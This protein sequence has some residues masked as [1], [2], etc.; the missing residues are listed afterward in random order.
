MNVKKPQS[1]PQ[2]ATLSFVLLS[3][4]SFKY[5]ENEKSIHNYFLSCLFYR[6]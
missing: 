2:F 5:I 6:P 4:K 1:L 3:L